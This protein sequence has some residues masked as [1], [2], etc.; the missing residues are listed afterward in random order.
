MEADAIYEQRMTHTDPKGMLGSISEGLFGA[1]REIKAA[2]DTAER[3]RWQ[4]Y[5]K[6][7]DGPRSDV[8]SVMAELIADDQIRCMM[9]KYGIGEDNE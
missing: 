2:R 4:A 3:E 1:S 6:A 9:E 8:P 5:Q 7:Y